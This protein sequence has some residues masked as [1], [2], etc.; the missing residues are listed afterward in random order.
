VETSDR[1]ILK[2]KEIDLYIPEKKFGIEFNGVYWHT[3]ANGKG[4]TYHYDKW[5]DA[6]TA[7]VELV[8]VW[9][10][11]FRDRKDA[12]L[13]MLARKLGVAD[14]LSSVHPQYSTEA[15]VALSKDFTP[16][17]LSV[18][19]AMDFMRE[20]AVQGFT[21]GS[22]YLGLVNTMQQVKAVL[23]LDSNRAGM[24][25]ISYTSVG[26]IDGGMKTLLEYASA[27][28][29]ISSFAGFSDNCM[30]MENEFVS[31]GLTA[32]GQVAPDYWYVVNNSRV[33]Q[34]DYPVDRFRDDAT[35]MFTAGFSTDELAELNGMPKIWDAGKTMFT[36]SL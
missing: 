5:N 19:V 13:K 4:S 15:T 6:K 25:V 24:S 17:P 33:P 3:E 10:D 20:N 27:A 2:G 28:Y 7:G 18:D 31:A 12:V 8:Q 22:H 32:S 36:I 1:K 30:G 14:K 21:A 35:L 9:E 16:T 34:Q 26:L 11:D 29:N 23:V